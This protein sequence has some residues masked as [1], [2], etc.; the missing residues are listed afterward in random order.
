MRKNCILD[1]I[2]DSKYSVGKKKLEKFLDYFK[3]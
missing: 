3:K 2:R 1:S